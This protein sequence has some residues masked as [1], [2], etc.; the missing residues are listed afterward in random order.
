MP[1]SAERGT[2]TAIWWVSGTAR[3]SPPAARVPSGLC[4]PAVS[5]RPSPTTAALHGAAVFMFVPGSAGTGLPVPLPQVDVEP[6]ERD[7][8][9]APWV[10][11]LAP[12]LRHEQ[13]VVAV[14]EDVEPRQVEDPGQVHRVGGIDVRAGPVV[15]AGRI[16]EAADARA[17]GD[18]R[19]LAHVR[20]AVAALRDDRDLVAAAL[21]RDGDLED[22]ILGRRGLDAR[23][24]ADDDLL[25]VS[26]AAHRHLA[27]VGHRTVRG[28]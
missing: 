1:A 15:V 20:A 9:A 10:R 4:T 25:G 12:D 7:P 6:L 23:A 11:H 28:S 14:D 16:G 19:D 27:L 13:R 24:D 3:M 8:V 17:E 2:T 18:D 21:E 5:K 26:R 22:S